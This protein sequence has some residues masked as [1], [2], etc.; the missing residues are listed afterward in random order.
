M[1]G[2]AFAALESLG[3]DGVAATGESLVE[4][5]RRG[6]RLSHRRIPA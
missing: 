4:S 2:H 3:A 5:S 1:C 6:E